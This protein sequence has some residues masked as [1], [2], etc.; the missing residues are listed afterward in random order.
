MGLR[1][2]CIGLQQSIYIGYPFW[3]PGEAQPKSEYPPSSR[4][5][6]RKGAL[7]GLAVGEDQK[8]VLKHLPVALPKHNMGL[9]F[10]VPIVG[11]S[12]RMLENDIYSTYPI[13][14]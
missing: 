7:L 11:V 2:Y 3:V 5:I 6:C 13:P 4:P 1:Q 14:V 10:W 12:L 8:W 9:V